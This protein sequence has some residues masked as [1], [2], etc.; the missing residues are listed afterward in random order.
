METYEVQSEALGYGIY[1]CHKQILSPTAWQAGVGDKFEDY[2]LPGE[3]G[4][5]II[6]V[7]NLKENYVAA[8][9]R[10]LAV[11]DRIAA[12]PLTDCL[13]HSRLVGIPLTPDVR[14]AV[15]A[16]APG[17]S[18]QIICNLVSMDTGLEITSGLGAGIIVNFKTTM[19][20]SVNA[21]N[22]ALQWTS[23]DGGDSIFVV[24]HGGVWWFAGTGA[25]R[26]N[27]CFCNEA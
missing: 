16:A 25:S 24:N 21:I 17:G 12:Y 22:P 5:V 3:E 13:G 14:M 23:G 2:I 7:L 19:E 18:Q 26:T 8:G 20:A 4:P 1:N 10:A 11:G 15:L 27:N 6:E 9:D